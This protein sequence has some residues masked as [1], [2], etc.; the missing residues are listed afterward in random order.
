M[1]HERASGGEDMIIFSGTAPRLSFLPGAEGDDLP[2]GSSNNTL[3]AAFSFTLC[4]F[5]DSKDTDLKSVN[6]LQN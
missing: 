6:R 4:N 3:N 5:E 1:T 2:T